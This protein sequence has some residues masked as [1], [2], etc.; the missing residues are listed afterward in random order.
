L[1]HEAG[2]GKDRAVDSPSLARHQMHAATA[3][4]VAQSSILQV[5]SV[6]GAPDAGQIKVAM[7][8]KPGILTGGTSISEGMVIS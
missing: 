4:M 1:F 2:H 7:S 8:E 6:S 5:R 3:G